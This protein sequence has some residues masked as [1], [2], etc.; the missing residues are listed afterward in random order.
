MAKVE[1]KTPII[2]EIKEN[3]DGAAG[4]VLV[5]ARGMTVAEDT[6]MRK[7]LREAGVIYKVYKNTMMRRAFE[8]TEYESLDE[9]L[10]GPSAIA[11]SKDDAV[12]P[13]RII[14]K[15]AKTIECLEFKSGVIEGKLVSVDEIVALANIPSRDVLLSK[16]LGSLQSPIANFARVIKQIAEKDPSEAVEESASSVDETEDTAATEDAKAE[17]KEPETEAPSDA[18]ESSEATEEVKAEASEEST[19]EEE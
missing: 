13:A 7:E 3:I 8:G 14:N 4:V 12:A 16:L 9:F 5:N 11:I 15:Y 10:S 19:T 1:L 18:A 17:A 6:V 2:N